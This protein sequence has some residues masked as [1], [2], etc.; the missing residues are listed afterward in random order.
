[1]SAKKPLT[2]KQYEVF[3]KAVKAR[4]S[5]MCDGFVVLGFHPVTGQPIEIWDFKDEKSEMALT[6]L[7]TLAGESPC[8]EDPDDDKE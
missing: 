6:T 5:E 4:M 2:K 8:D 1:M 3:K 7:V